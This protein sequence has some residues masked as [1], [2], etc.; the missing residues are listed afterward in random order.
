MGFAP[1]HRATFGALL[2]YAPTESSQVMLLSSAPEGKAKKRALV[3][4]GGMTA[5]LLDNAY[6]TPLREG[7]MEREVSLAQVQLRSCHHQYGMKTLDDDVADIQAALACL[8]YDLDY[9]EFVLV[10]HSTGCQ[11]LAHLAQSV[12]NKQ[13]CWKATILQA[14]VSDRENLG[15]KEREALALAE[16]SA[17]PDEL[18]PRKVCGDVPMTARRA[19]ALWTRLGQDDYFS[20]DLK[21]EELAERLQALG[22]RPTLFLLSGA[23]EYAGGSLASREDAAHNAHGQRMARLAGGSA[24]HAVVP[25]A[26]HD[27]RNRVDE[28]ARMMLEFVDRVWGRK[29]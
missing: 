12:T 18:L 15:D 26:Y 21:D 14:P 29:A 1:H 17:D 23:D 19:K 28:V 10:G 13:A 20:T 4:V 2:R 24:E 5:G 6:L 7:L 8:Q 9:E 27:G 11:D 22:Q 25:G 16:A 3:Y